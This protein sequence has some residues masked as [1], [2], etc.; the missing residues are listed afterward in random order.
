MTVALGAVL[1]VGAVAVA[2]PAFA[3]CTPT[4]THELKYVNDHEGYN[5]KI[6][7]II[8][9]IYEYYSVYT[10]ECGSTKEAVVLVDNDGSSSYKVYVADTDCDS[11]GPYWHAWATG[12]GQFKDGAGGCG[13]YP[14]YTVAKSSI[15]IPINWWVEWGGHNS[16][17]TN[18]P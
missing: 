17:V 18:F 7:G 15:G 5:P 6:D 9:P 14:E 16:P 3:A 1:S 4:F 10:I 11:I 2:S 12:G 13:S 8:I